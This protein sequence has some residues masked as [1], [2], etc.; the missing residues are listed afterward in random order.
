VSPEALAPPG[1]PPRSRPPGGPGAAPR[2]YR[3]DVHP[4]RGG[5]RAGLA[6]DA[7]RGLTRDPKELSPK[8]LYDERGSALFEEIT[9]LPEYYQGRAELEILRRAAPGLAARHRPSE[10]VELGAGAARKAEVLLAAMRDGGG[11][12]RYVPFDVCAEMLLQAA[13]RLS[14]AYP[15]LRVHGVAGDFDH[16]LEG[17]PPREGPGPR[18]IAFLGGTVGNLAPEARGPFMGA[19]ARLM[20]ADD[21]LLV[22]T[23]LAGEPARIVPA[24]NDAA[25]VTAEFNLNLL[26]MLNRELDADFDLGAF[27]HEARYDPG[28]PWIEM[29]LRSRVDQTVRIGALGLEV[30]FRAGEEMRTEISCKFTRAGVE[31]M[32]AGAGLELVEWHVDARGWFAVSLARRRPAGPGAG[33]PGLSPA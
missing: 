24:Y 32:Y 12:V 27:A 2:P 28:P 8:Y 20:H 29:V 3:L 31:E 7:R 10:L 1:A 23:D 14:V 25:G 5:P 11:E 19:L 4:P 30:G 15:G 33:R 21:L 17:L 18:M 9:R 16:D 22:G 6:D 26:R 13:G